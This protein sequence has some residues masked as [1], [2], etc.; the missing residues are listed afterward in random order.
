MCNIQQTLLNN[1]KLLKKTST[2]PQLDVEVILSF[3][4]KKTKEFLYTHPEYKL[5]TR[6]L[7]K[8]TKLINRRLKHEPIAY[9][10]GE[11][12]FYGLNFIVN[13]NT[14]IPRPAT[15]T[16]VNTTLKEIQK[17]LTLDPSAPL[18]AGSRLL[19]LIDLG[20]GTGC[21]P[22]AIAKN[23]PKDIYKKI[24]IYAVDNSQ[25][26]LNIAQK[27]L[28][29]HRLGKKIKLIKGDLLKITDSATTPNPSLLRRGND[30]VSPPFEG[31]AGSGCVITTNL[32]Y[33]STS[34]YKTL[35]PDIKKYEPKQA[36]V[37]GQDGLK[38]YRKLF[39]QLSKGA[40]LPIGSLAP[41]TLT[42]RRK[43]S[44]A[45]AKARAHTYP[46]QITLIIEIDPQQVA[47]IKKI[48]KQNF[49]N[50]KTCAE[51]GRSIKIIKDLAGLNRVMVISF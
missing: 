31:G 18:R 13:K 5:N 45:S 40:K 1:I 37:A 11:K 29:K 22:I 34:Q 49:E 12:E 2:T 26:A 47:P 44:L 28:K 10:I 48:L 51:Q 16:L 25:K 4:L 3:I 50:Y 8:F 43:P 33:I 17:L 15:E 14:L 19:T 6:Q 27:N 21:I 24:N 30:D 41:L 38:Y 35:S 9:I 20:T 32:P 7:N 23:L 39:R 42:G 46:H 36:L